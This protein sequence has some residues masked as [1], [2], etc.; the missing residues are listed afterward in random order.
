MLLVVNQQY[1]WGEVFELC[2]CVLL[3]A[4]EEGS[5]SWSIA[6]FFAPAKH[7]V[8][9]ATWW[10]HPQNLEFGKLRASKLTLTKY[11]VGRRHH[12]RS[13]A[14][15][16]WIQNFIAQEPQLINS[17]IRDL[18]LLDKKQP[19]QS[20]CSQVYVTSNSFNKAHQFRPSQG[21]PFGYPWHYFSVIGKLNSL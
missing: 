7:V 12:V 8:A 17:I 4:M 5:L 19:N 9:L 15:H 21:A 1:E 16:S 18:G 3:L 13:L 14:I 2:V 11:Q 20:E 10:F 6:T